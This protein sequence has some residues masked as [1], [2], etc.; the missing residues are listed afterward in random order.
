MSEISFPTSASTTAME[1]SST[2]A[3]VKEED[4]DLSETAIKILEKEEINGRDFLKI[5][6]EKLRSIGMVLGPASRLSDFA[7]DL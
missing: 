1:D 4:L 7:K 5:S 3:H 6:E 2:L